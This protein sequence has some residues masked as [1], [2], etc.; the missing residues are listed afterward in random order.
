MRVTSYLRGWKW[1]GALLMTT[2]G[3]TVAWGEAPSRTAPLWTDVGDANVTPA[4]A[5]EQPIDETALAA[6]LLAER[7]AS[8]YDEALSAPE[9]AHGSSCRSCGG[10]CGS[11]CCGGC[12]HKLFGLFAPSDRCFSDFISPISN[13]L[14]FEDPRTLTELRAIFATQWIDAGNPV[15]GG[16]TAY[17]LAAQLRAA[18]TERLSII[19]NKDGYAWLY[20]TI[21]P[22]RSGMAN[23][24]VGLKYNLI[25]DPEAQRIWSI[26]TT[27][28]IPTGNTNVFQGQ[29]GGEFFSFLTGGREIF[30]YGHILTSVG[31]R[32]STTG[33][34]SD[35]LN[36]STH[37]DYEFRPRLYGV[38]EFN[39]FH[40]TRSGTL[41][42]VG[43]EGNDL[44]NLGAT[45]VAGNDIVTMA[46]GSRKRFGCHE[47]HE[48]GIGYEFP[49]T[50]RRDLLNDRLYLDLVLRY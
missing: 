36:W 50:T 6:E 32:Y 4:A 21:G 38:L 35:M 3:S 12:N 24:A 14:F 8:A 46:F 27:Y 49:L 11:T 39:W 16:G 29:A 9:G 15:F 18:I 37:L 1:V 26:G 33:E 22:N 30:D 43:F 13:P 44:F 34:L 42:P 45:N 31:Y 25:R 20:P 5:V 7:N 23:I 2:M 28:Q 40:W 48:A 41:L 10:G 47:M 19:A 17:Y